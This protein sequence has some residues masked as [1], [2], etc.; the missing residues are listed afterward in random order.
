MMREEVR[1]EARCGEIG[2][3]LQVMIMERRSGT[4]GR[5]DTGHQE[6]SGS[7]RKKRRTMGEQWGKLQQEKWQI[8]DRWLNWGGGDEW[9]GG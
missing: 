4:W 5:R 9:R 8:D 7:T 1:N 3:R 2:P 6:R